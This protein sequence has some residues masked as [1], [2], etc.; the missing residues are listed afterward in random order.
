V[1]VVVIGTGFGA[2]VVAP[3]FE[4][5]HGCRVLDVVSPRDPDAIGAALARP[6]VDLVS[7][8]SPPFLHAEHVRRGLAGGR[9]VLCDKPFGLDAGE[10]A[11]LLAL[12]EAT[13]SLHFCNFEFRFHPARM[14][15]RKLV[16]D[17]AIGTVEHV[18]WTYL[19]AGSRRPLR[20]F[21]WLFDAASG[22]GWVGAWASHAVDALRWWFGDVRVLHAVRHL[23]VAE[24]PDAAGQLQR[25]TAEDGVTATL[26]LAGGAVAVLDSSFA[27]ATTTPMRLVVAGSEG[28][29]ECVADQRLR[30]R[31]ADGARE[32]IPLDSTTEAD[33]HLL[34]MRRY[35]LLVRDAV[36][37]GSMPPYVPTFADGV[38]C[39]RVLDA[40]RAA[41]LRVRE[42]ASG[43]VDES[44][45]AGA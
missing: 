31:R 23:A 27:S 40:M 13:R 43:Q 8:H 15:V 22:G 1:N 30:L 33:P 35:A 34:P 20:R 2:R 26:V 44:R 18:Q 9:A 10:S 6:D 12:A 32:E 36:H 24:R 25:C 17:G 7:V 39:D 4:D 37:E 29:L 11:E 19:G 28:V 41:P 42:G 3:V 16:R 45:T 38:A 14:M 21:G 5:T